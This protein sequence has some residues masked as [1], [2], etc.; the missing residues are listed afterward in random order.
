MK[1]PFAPTE[2]KIAVI[3]GGTGSFTLLS[4]LKDHTSQIAALVNMVDDGGSTGVL[5][6]ELGA[7]P[8]GD[9]RQCLVALSSSPKVRDLF[10]YRFEE[11]TFQG[12][13]FGNIL[14]SALERVTGNFSEAVETASEI[15][16]VNGVVIPAT[17]DNI[18]LKLEWP[19]ASTI[20][21]GERVIDAEYFQYDPRRATLSLMP[22]AT[23]NPLALAA[24]RD[25]DLI[26]IAPGDLYTSLGPLLII[27]G[28]GDA[29]RASKATKIY[30]SNL[31]T[32]RGQTEGFSVADHADEIERFAGHQF[33]DYVIYNHQQP[34]EA[35]AA[36]YSEEDAYLVAANHDQLAD[37]HYKSVGGSFLGL[38]AEKDEA[39]KLPRS[40]IRHDPAAVA[41]AIIEVYDRVRTER[42]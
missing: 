20:L 11:G 33:L 42:N 12:H 5:R 21:H 2:R 32:K 6:D 9:I 16:R 4:S 19:E 23:A 25:A 36:R 40:L 3:G 10:N 1:D 31:V 30:V 41:S 29:L 15:L 38:I 26:V 37:R 39:D 27:D 22:S 14:L 13:S 28:I 24:I 7:L 35:L 8:P 17:L 18:R 34:D